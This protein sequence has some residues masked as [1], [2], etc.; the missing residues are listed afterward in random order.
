MTS[1]P[2]IAAS[3]Y[4]GWCCRLE[5]DRRG[6]GGLLAALIAW[7][8]HGHDAGHGWWRDCVRDV[9]YIQPDWAPLRDKCRYARAVFIMKQMWKPQAILAD[10]MVWR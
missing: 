2:L 9:H 3:A 5:S 8:W 7:F 1:P 6:F 10:L 4:P